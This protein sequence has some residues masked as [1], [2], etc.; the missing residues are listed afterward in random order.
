LA[1]FKVRTLQ[2]CSNSPE[3]KGYC[4]ARQQDPAQTVASVNLANH[5]AMKG[6][7]GEAIVLWE[8]ALSRNS[9]SGI[10]KNQYCH[11]LFAAGGPKG[12]ERA[13]RKAL[14]LNPALKSARR[15]LADPRISKSSK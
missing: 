11:R 3:R 2:S 8:E 7:T 14:E 13:L 4:R 6:Q 1:A 12:A 9:W 10:C 15:L 5:L